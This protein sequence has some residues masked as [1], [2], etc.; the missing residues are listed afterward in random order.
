MTN[1][2]EAARGEECFNDHRGA[3]LM[4]PTQKKEKKRQP[5]LQ[6]NQ[7]AGTKNGEGE[8]KD[9]PSAVA[10]AANSDFPSTTNETKRRNRSSHKACLARLR[11]IISSEKKG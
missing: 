8:K 2:E 1:T 3:H 11:R 5:S 9:L 6:K 7:G 4:P 10:N